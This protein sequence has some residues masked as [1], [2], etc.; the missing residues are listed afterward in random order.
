[1]NIA[2][3]GATGNV[4]RKIIEV[5]EKKNFPITE[6]FL[7]ASSKSAGKKINFN[8]KELVVIDLE[9]FDFSKVKIAFFAAGSSIAEKWASLVAEKTIVIDN[10]KFFRKD[11]DI[12]L[13]VPEVNSKDLVNVK[14]KNIIANAN[15]SVI[16]LV[17]ALKPLHDLYN[18]KRVVVSTYQS[19]SGAG[20]APMDELLSQTKEYFENRNLESKY[21]TKQIAFNIIPHIDSFLDNG[22]T[23]EEQKTTDEVKKILDKKI[24][25]TS[26]C[27]R[28]PVLVSHSISANV[29]FDKKFNLEEIKDVLSTS[30]GCKVIDERKDG[31]YITPVEAENRYETFISR[32]RQDDSQTNSVNLWIVSDNLLKGAALNAVEIAEGLI[33]KNLHER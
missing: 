19:V 30:P 28:I 1:M 9:K 20:K 33:K 4:G 10:S 5:L 16:P 27:V 25:I 21:F 17:V 26:T 18:V 24:K 14:N 11:P 22:Y 3:V 13:I 23:K 15:C 8:N 7:I 12:P 32:I 2:I 29:E 31:G 6:L